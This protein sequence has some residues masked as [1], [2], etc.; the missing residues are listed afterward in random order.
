MSSGHAH[1]YLPL[2]EN[3][4]FVRRTN[5]FD[6]LEKKLFQERRREVAL[7]GLGGAGKTQIALQLAYDVKQTR[8]EHSIFWVSALS[9]ES[10]DRSCA[11]IADELGIQDAKW[12][13]KE[14]LHQYLQT[15]T[16]GK[17][18]IIIDNADD[19]KILYGTAD[20]T[21]GL[22]KYVA[23]PKDGQILFTTRSGDVARED[24]QRDV[25][26]I[27]KMEFDEAIMLMKELSVPETLLQSREQTMNLL[28]ELTYLPLAIAQ[29]SAYLRRNGISISKYLTLPRS[30][31]K[32]MVDLMSRAFN[33]N[34]LYEKAQRAVATTWLV[35][36]EQIRENDANAADVLGFLS[37]IEPKMIPESLLSEFKNFTESKL[38]EAIG[39]LS[40]F[41]FLKRQEGSKFLDMHSLVHLAARVWLKESGQAEATIESALEQVYARFLDI[42]WETRMIQMDYLPHALKITQDDMTKQMETRYDLIHEVALSLYE[43]GRFAE[44][45][46]SGEDSLRWREQHLVEDHFK[47]LESQ[48]QL[49]AA[50]KG[51]GQVKDAISSLERAVELASKTMAEDDLPRLLCQ[52]RLAQAYKRNGQTKDAIQMLER[53][54]EIQS[55]KL[56]EDDVAQ[57]SAQRM[58]ASAYL[59]NGQIKEAIRLLE[60]IVEIMP[61][62]LAE[63]HPLRLGAQHSLAMAYRREG[64]VK[65]AIRLL[66]RIVTTESKTLVQDHPDQLT[67]QRSLAVA[68]RKQGRVKDAIRLLERIV[69][70]K[71][72]TLPE[73]S[74]NRLASQYELAKAYQKD[75]ETEKAVELLEH[76]VAIARRTLA[77]DH[78]KR[79]KMERSLSKAR[80]RSQRSQ[81]SARENPLLAI[82]G[83]EEKAHS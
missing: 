37:C 40:E 75:D 48:Y 9:T 41:A 2:H 13:S 27:P 28:K 42:R 83:V 64:Q 12:D 15:D 72:K 63:D 76:I 60:Q 55:S 4:H 51:N 18:I 77:S 46:I 24:Y 71:S 56:A 52:S 31:E 50:Y 33:D 22:Y 25:I 62:N 54:V 70:V 39:T 44:S 81:D 35:S 1:Y 79:L 11:A 5:I 30:E 47:L 29:A 26:E 57:L 73:D 17:C 78:V 8:P 7:V 21:G 67:M 65:D 53:V 34:N 82:R 3:E 10:F 16:A 58:L 80:Q 36:F 66:E 23:D 38:I 49:G 45:V 6:A 14:L 61:R 32:V 74:S 68:Y 69:E 19:G 20:N 43:E 59:D